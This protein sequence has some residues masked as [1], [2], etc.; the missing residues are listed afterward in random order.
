MECKT[1]YE[2]QYTSID[3][4]DRWIGLF[5]ENGLNMEDAMREFGELKN[6]KKYDERVARL[7][8]VRITTVEEVIASA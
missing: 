7:R 5:S 1:V 3:E 6:K 2:P 8:L 4:P